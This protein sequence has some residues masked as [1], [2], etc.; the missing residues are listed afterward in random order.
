MNNRQFIRN[1][2]VDEAGDP[3][4]F[5]SRGKIIVDTFGCSKYFIL[6][7]LDIPSPED[8][9]KKLIQLRL[10]LLSDPYFSDVPSMQLDSRKTALAFHA[11]DDIPE[12]RKEV[13]SLL[14]EC[15]LKFYAV[16][17]DKSSVIN[18]VKQMNEKK[19]DYRYHPN[20]LYDYM[21]RRLFRDKL[22]KDDS[23]SICFARRGKSDR[24]VALK[25]SLENARENFYKKWGVLGA[26]PINVYAS[27]NLESP[28]LQAVDYFLWSLQ[29]LYER[30]EERYVIYL[31]QL[32][33]LV[34]DIDDTR[35]KI[36]GVYYTQKNPL[37]L[38]KIK[39]KPEI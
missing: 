30:H 7:V 37:R 35:N 19:P 1:Y 31:W 36:Y 25:E 21:I 32:I 38:D 5:S 29:R 2:F 11:K 20:E 13:F 14:S 26:A 28:G 24:T 4:I 23:Y 16:V 22:H 39:R 10:D 34:H 27:S 33:H 3:N 18:Y 8:F 12:V 17:R 9:G 15:D 6:G